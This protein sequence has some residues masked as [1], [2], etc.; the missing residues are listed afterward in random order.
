MI[1]KIFICCFLFSLLGCN[2]TSKK[3]ELLDLNIYIKSNQKIDS[4]FISNIAQD[5]EFMF[6]PFSNTIK[7]NL[8]DSIN[9]LYNVWLFA[10]GKQYSGN[11]NQFWLNGE[12]IIIKGTFNNGFKVDTVIGSPLYYKGLKFRKMYSNLYKTNPTSTEIDYFLLDY[13]KENIDNLLS[14]HA[15]NYFMFKNK[16]DKIKINQ[17]K[18][19]IAS[20]PK[21]FKNHTVLNVHDGI[22]KILNTT[23]IDIGKY[24]FISKSGKKTTIKL[25]NNK[26]YLLDLWF[27]NCPPCIEDHQ[28]FKDNPQ[29]LADRNIEMIGISTDNNQEK[30][31]DFLTKKSYSWKNY[32]QASYQGSMTEDLIVEVF[33]TY[34]LIEGN[35]KIVQTFN[36][37]ND[38]ENYL[39]E[40]S[41]N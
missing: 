14:L 40:E 9:D 37:Y 38:I 32:R 15:A 28:K 33:P 5:R 27:I 20:H 4:V 25:T 6:I 35:G 17:L 31:S 30:W 13:T 1:T 39:Q 7:I 23:K 3:D 21:N 34:F 36:D 22:E 29:L 19:V 8:K 18:K 2:T 41:T 12:K 26:R 11:E 24:D 10:D 16:N